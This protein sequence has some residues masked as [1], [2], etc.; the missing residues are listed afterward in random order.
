MQVR[1][2][3]FSDGDQLT[4]VDDTLDRLPGLLRAR[5]VE[6]GLSQAEAAGAAGVSQSMLARIESGERTPSTPVLFRLLDALQ[7]DIGRLTS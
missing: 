3:L 2:P 1:R 4:L 7:T 6:L 5:R